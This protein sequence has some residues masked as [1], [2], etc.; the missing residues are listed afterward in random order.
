[1]L[2]ALENMLLYRPVRS[3]QE[4]LPPPSGRVQDITLTTADGTRIH[5]WW[6]PTDNW[7]PAQG[8][9]LYCHG[10]AGNLSHRG[11][12]ILRWQE[13][14]GQ[15]VL[16]FDYPGYGRSAGRPS[17]PGCYAAADAAYDW[18]VQARQVRPERI[19]L[20]G[21]SLGGGVAVDVASRRPHRALVL[22]GT[23]T[24]VPDMA[25]RLY[26]WLPVRRLMR[27]HFDN[28]GKIGRCR[29]PVFV[30][31]GDCD[32]LVPFAMG[33]RLFAAATEPKHFLPLEGCDHNHA[34]GPE[35]FGALRDFLECT[36]APGL[37]PRSH[38][39]KN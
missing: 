22:V 13:A 30:A 33:E 37:D 31:H 16:I 17:E 4:W 23:F 18:L 24:S 29:E 6:C 1:V 28:L 8:A 15:A 35:F 32:S 2:L 11:E 20:Y 36:D 14:L 12:G 19:L 5:A 7:E 38:L 39:S 9:L 3:S 25:G 10:N 26:P 34:P 27:N 21:G